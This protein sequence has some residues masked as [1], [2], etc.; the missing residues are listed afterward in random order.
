MAPRS[1]NV[2]TATGQ[3]R[4]NRRHIIPLPS[5]QPNGSPIDANTNL[6]TVDPPSGSLPD[7]ACTHTRSG[8][9]STPLP[10]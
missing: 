2:Q 10:V 3:Y 6:Q 9:A 1:Y 7:T 5:D 4:Y 8:H